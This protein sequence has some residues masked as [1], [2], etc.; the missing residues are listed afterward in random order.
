MAAS[1]ASREHEA[2]AQ[3][4]PWVAAD[5][6]LQP[7]LP[8]IVEREAQYSQ[9]L[10][11]ICALEGSLQAFCF[12]GGLH[13]FGLQRGDGGTWYRE[14]APAASAAS[15]I[16]DFNGW[17]PL[18]HPCRHAEDGT[19]EV[20]VPDLPDGRPALRPGCRYKVALRLSGSDE[21]EDRVP[22]WARQTVQ[23]Q[24]SGDFM[25]VV[26]ADDLLGRRWRHARPAPPPSLHV[27]EAHVPRTGGLEPSRVAGRRRLRGC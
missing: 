6:L 9:V 17:N 26:P 24:G 21:W 15:L 7:W 10:S 25:A 14:W 11:N 5:P 3:C 8:E 16:G 22:A 23:E 4:W 2:E 13:R 20:F 1:A 27:Y 18:A 19:F 12:A